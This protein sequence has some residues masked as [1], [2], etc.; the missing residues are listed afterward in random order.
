MSKTW[1]YCLKSLKETL[2]LKDF[3]LWVQPLKAIEKD[4]ILTL[5]AP[6]PAILKQTTGRLKKDITKTVAKENKSIKINIVLSESQNI[7]TTLSLLRLSGK[8]SVNELSKP[9]KACSK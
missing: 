3:T 6:N 2:S 1:N 4:F 7:N 9:Y 5:V 8:S